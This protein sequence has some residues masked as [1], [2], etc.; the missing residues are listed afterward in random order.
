VRS[1]SRS[2]S[3]S[4][5]PLFPSNNDYTDTDA[6]TS[7]PGTTFNAEGI[8]AETQ[9]RL[10]RTG[11]KGVIQD[12]NEAVSLE[13]AKRAQEIKETNRRM[14]K[15]ALTAR[16]FAEDEEERLLQKAKEG[17]TPPQ[18]GKRLFERTSRGGHL[19]EIDEAGFL[20]AIDGEMDGTWVVL[21]IYD[22]VR[23][24]GSSKA[25]YSHTCSLLRDATI[26]TLFWPV[27]LDNTR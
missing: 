21:H 16:T 17:V 18:I 13:R 6:S 12:H 8:P 14:E 23:L 5:D 19:R 20:K 26:S 24:L 27:L 3:A 25:Q 22:P 7:S 10:G 15:M 9:T 1:P 11:V 2:R 4:P